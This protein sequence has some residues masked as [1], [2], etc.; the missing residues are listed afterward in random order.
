[1]KKRGIK[2]NFISITL[3]ILSLCVLIGAVSVYFIYDKKLIGFILIV[4]GL[5]TLLSSKLFNI[6]ISSLWPDIIF[7]V[8]DNGILAIIAI[9]GADFAGVLGAI[10]G[11]VVGNT[12]TDGI[13]GIFEGYTAEIS[14]KYKINEKRTTLGSA[15]GK[16]SG[17]LFGAGIVLIFAWLINSF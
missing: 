15:I 9:I 1:M 5:I 16:M 6:S 10:V 4:L 14:R 13:A 2:K 11:G 7:G 17:C 12:I 8:I 3:T